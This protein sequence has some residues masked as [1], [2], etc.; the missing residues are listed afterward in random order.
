MTVHEKGKSLLQRGQLQEALQVFLLADES[1][2]LCNPTFI[3]MIDNGAHLALDIVWTMFLLRDID[4]LRDA[5]AYLKKAEEGF[6]RAHGEN[7]ER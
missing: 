7:L 3:S 6:K 1:L 2:D 5:R 4:R